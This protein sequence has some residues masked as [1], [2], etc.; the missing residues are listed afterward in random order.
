MVKIGKVSKEKGDYK[1]VAGQLI[2]DL[3]DFK[4]G[5][6]FSGPPW[7]SA[8]TPSGPPAR[9]PCRISSAATRTF[10]RTPASRSSS[11]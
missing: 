5:K 2:D 9:G 7:R 10:P 1:A 3:Y 6:V 11:G 4:D 8:R